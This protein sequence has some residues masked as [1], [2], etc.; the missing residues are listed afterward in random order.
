[1]HTKNK[2]K[3][4]TLTNKNKQQPKIPGGGCLNTFYW[5]SITSIFNKQCRSRSDAA[6]FLVTPERRKMPRHECTFKF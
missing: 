3:F 1:M 4:G 5:L 6:E 2:D